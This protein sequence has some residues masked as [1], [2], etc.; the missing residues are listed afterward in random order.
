M[1][2]VQYKFPT[3]E[4]V[5]SLQDRIEELENKIDEMK[6][7]GENMGY[8]PNE[9]Q[10]YTSGI[11][12]IFNEKYFYAG[13]DIESCAKEAREIGYQLMSFNGD[14]YFIGTRDDPVEIQLP[15]QISDFQ[16]S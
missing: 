8:D 4:W 9:P 16:V 10:I 14:V 3:S 5:K 7:D 13:Q 15:L 11:R 2:K 6:K 1:G 12:K